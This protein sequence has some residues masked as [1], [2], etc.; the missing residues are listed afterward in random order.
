M[1]DDAGCR[2]NENAPLVICHCS[3][4][5]A[6]PEPACSVCGHDYIPLDEDGHCAN[7]A[8]R[9]DESCEDYVARCRE[10]RRTK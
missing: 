6:P 2:V 3:D 8:P 9:E 10:I 4:C 7:C 5:D 1:G